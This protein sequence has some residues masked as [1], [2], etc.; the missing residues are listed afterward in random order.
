M[1]S[2][3]TRRNQLCSTR[4]MWRTSPSSEMLDGGTAL[5]ASC[6]AVEPVALEGKGA[7][8]VLEVA[9]E[10]LA[11]AARGALLHPRVLVLGQPHAVEV[12]G[13]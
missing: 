9:D 6:S 2:S 12:H 10:A 7:A 8:V 13:Q 5:L 11:L 3:M 4:A 1:R